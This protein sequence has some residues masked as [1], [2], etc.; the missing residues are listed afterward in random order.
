MK[1]SSILAQISRQVCRRDIVI[2]LISATISA[3]ATAYALRA[4]R[5]ATE[6]LSPAQAMEL[7]WRMAEERQCINKNYKLGSKSFKVRTDG[8][9]LYDTAY[10]GGAGGE[11]IITATNEP[12]PKFT[13]HPQY[14]S[15]RVSTPALENFAT[16]VSYCYSSSI[17]AAYRPENFLKDGIA[18]QSKLTAE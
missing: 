12:T 13:T 16:V 6:T 5:P 17:S 14:Y 1:A 10:N 9:T 7:N 3:A 2:A 8:V 4:L 11:A 15:T 18:P